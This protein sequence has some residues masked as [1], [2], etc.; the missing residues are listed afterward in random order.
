MRAGDGQG[1][2]LR[3]ATRTPEGRADKRRPCCAL[4]QWWHA[5][6]AAPRPVCATQPPSRAPRAAERAAARAHPRVPTRPG[7]RERQPSPHTQPMTMPC[8][9]MHCCP[10]GR[11]ACR[12]QKACPAGHLAPAALAPGARRC[13]AALLAHPHRRGLGLRSASWTH[14]QSTSSSL[15]RGPQQL[16]LQ[17]TRPAVPGAPQRGRQRRAVGMRRPKRWLQHHTHH[18]R[19]GCILGR[20]QPRLCM[21]GSTP[22]CSISTTSSGRRHWAARHRGSLHR[23]ASSTLAKA[24]RVAPSLVLGGPHAAWPPPVPPLGREALRDGRALR[25]QRHS[26]AWH[27]RRG[28]EPAA[29]PPACRRHGQGT[30]RGRPAWAPPRVMRRWPSSLTGEHRQRQGRLRRVGGHACRQPPATFRCSGHCSAAAA[31]PRTAVRA[32]LRSWCGPPSQA[33]ASAQAPAVP[34]ALAAAGYRGA[35]C[36]LRQAPRVTA[37]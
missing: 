23:C 8:I 18:K 11:C 2:L 3:R 22:T 35:A 24:P 14:W 36:W 20:L 1:V 29:P 16:L 28:L 9:V 6:L 21:G 15:T 30:R 12:A 19:P 25:A 7:L 5:C 31:R 37:H 17:P 27:L 26:P 33:R 32:A 34:Q 10:D 4:L 13:Q